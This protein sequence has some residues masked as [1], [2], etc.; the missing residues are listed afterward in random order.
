MSTCMGSVEG[1][2]EAG[3]LKYATLERSRYVK[4]GYRFT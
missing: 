2:M 1:H 4:E 3:F